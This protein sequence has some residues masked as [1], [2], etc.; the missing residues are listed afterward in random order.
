MNK[1]NTLRAAA[2]LAVALSSATLPASL[3]AQSFGGGFS[4]QALPPAAAPGA[5]AAEVA[6][7][8]MLDYSLPANSLGTARS[9]PASAF[10][11]SFG[12]TD[13]RRQDE[14][15]EDIGVM[16]FLLE[17]NLERALGNIPT[18][19]L[20]IPMVAR[21]A[22]ARS[23]HGMYLE[24]YGAIFIVKVNFP[25]V[26]PVEPA[27]TNV[28]KP[29]DTEWDSARERLYGQAG[30]PR[31]VTYVR[32]AR[33]GDDGG[34]GPLAQKRLASSYRAGRVRG[35]FGRRRPRAGR[36]WQRSQR[37]RDCGRR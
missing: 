29:A 23:A 32:G 36:N 10:I 13:A 6:P 12:R 33:R 18:M 22:T 26:G 25:L 17:K 21:D 4:S 28:A 34:V 19:K 3:T 37:G 8:Q 5:S 16:S 27:Q 1:R 15:Q 24:G 11:L 20:G 7:G 35:D 2:R 14:L 31:A 30:D 9:R